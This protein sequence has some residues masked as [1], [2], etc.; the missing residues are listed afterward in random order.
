VENEAE[1]IY[2]RATWRLLRDGSADGAANMAVDEAILLAVAEGVAP[3]TL[4]FYMWEPPCLSIGY[5]Q[6]MEE[7]V[8]LET[9]RARGVNWVRRPTG[10]RSILHTDE[11]T[12]GVVAPQN[13][14]RVAGG[15]VESYRRLSQGLLAGLRLL[16]VEVV[17]ARKSHDRRPELAAACFDSPSL[18]EITVG[19]KKLVGSAQVRRQ[20]MVLQHGSLPLCGDLTRIF[21]YLRLESEKKRQALRRALRA[22]AATLE[23]VLGRAVSFDETAE[24]LAAGFA[25]ALNLNLELGRLTARERELAEQARRERYA[26]DEW[27]FRK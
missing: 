11:L 20:G 15:V 17:Q 5:S 23:E 3:P 14:P 18:Y 16:G 8:D 13:E 21:D 4:R 26:T 6:S 12:Y 2:P 9:C 19:D 27:N 22:R 7:E 24:A 25:Q 1:G 10:G